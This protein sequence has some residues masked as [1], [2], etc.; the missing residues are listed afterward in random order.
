MTGK[1]ADPKKRGWRIVGVIAGVL[2]LLGV[3]AAV[4]FAY[5]FDANPFKPRI[6]AAVQQQTGRA[7]AIEGEMSLALLPSPHATLRQLRLAEAAGFGDQAFAEVGVVS[8]YPRLTPLLRGRI[9]IREIMLE[10]PRLHLQKN[11]SGQSNWADLLQQ[12]SAEAQ[13]PGSDQ[14]PPAAG[15]VIRGLRIQDGELTFDDH[16]TTRRLIASNLNLRAGGFGHASKAM[17]EARAD[18]LGEQP[19]F[20]GALGLSGQVAVDQE[21]G[22]YEVTD[23]QLRF[24][25]EASAPITFTLEMNG[26]GEYAGSRES[27]SGTVTVVL[28]DSAG[29]VAAN[30]QATA[31]ADAEAPPRID[32]RL[33]V[34]EFSLRQLL[35]R[36]GKAVP[37]MRDNAALSRAQFAID[38][39]GD[40]ERLVLRPTGRLDDSNLHGQITMQGG[41]ERPVIRFD[42]AVDQIDLDRYRPPRPPGSP[43]PDT[44]DAISKISN[45][46]LRAL[47]LNIRGE[48]RVGTITLNGDR[49]SNFVAKLEW[50]P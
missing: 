1:R 23:L 49:T 5:F 40:Q 12:R 50:N 46:E 26:K 38:V 41:F 24:D 33:S 37:A 47:G 15:V 29:Q 39:S 21:A 4:Y 3:V 42:L 19:K 10:R 14:V 8:I 6:V 11:K 30:A 9:E 16:A 43:S 44:E 32:A 22:L 27:L 36:L 34:P 35:T 45:E 2:L 18:I 17:I 31:S 20:K 7:L 13:S 48:L 28:K 25:G